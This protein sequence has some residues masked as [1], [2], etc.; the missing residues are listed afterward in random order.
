MDRS[1]NADVASRIET[2]VVSVTNPYRMGV[3]VRYDWV[4]HHPSAVSVGHPTGPTNQS[5]LVAVV[6]TIHGGVNATGFTR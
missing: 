3:V 4:S 5:M 2:G 6:T 1:T